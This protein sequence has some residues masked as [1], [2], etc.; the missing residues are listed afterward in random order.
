MDGMEVRLQERQTNQRPLSGGQRQFDHL[1]EEM[2]GHL[3]LLLQIQLGPFVVWHCKCKMIQQRLVDWLGDVELIV[4]AFWVLRC[5]ESC[6]DREGRDS[7]TCNNKFVAGGAATG[8]LDASYA[9]FLG[10]E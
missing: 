3:T 4:F 9:A 1:G 7:E 6:Q 5:S 8:S 10:P 2:V